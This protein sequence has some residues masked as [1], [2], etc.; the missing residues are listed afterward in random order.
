MI[1]GKAHLFHSLI[2][3][4]SKEKHNEMEG[5]FKKRIK[6]V[7][8]QH[9]LKVFMLELFLRFYIGVYYEEVGSPKERSVDPSS[10][11]VANEYLVKKMPFTA[12]Q[13]EIYHELMDIVYPGLLILDK[14]YQTRTKEDRVVLIVQRALFERE[15]LKLL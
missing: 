14:P 12:Q 5:V 1:L 11:L 9:Y 2:N 7:N 13:K 15:L 8:R 6:W 4:Y 10:V 3:P